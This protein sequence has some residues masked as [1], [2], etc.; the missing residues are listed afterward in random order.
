MKDCR[1]LSFIGKI[2]QKQMQFKNVLEMLKKRNE[3]L[4]NTLFYIRNYSE[5]NEVA[6][7]YDTQT[8]GKKMC[9]MGSLTG[10]H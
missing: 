10:K 5:T 2:T 8:T 6:I 3:G 9:V 1:I 4:S 7:F